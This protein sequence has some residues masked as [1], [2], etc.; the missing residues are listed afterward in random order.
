MAVRAGSPT[1]GAQCNKGSVSLDT[2]I[3]HVECVESGSG[4]NKHAVVTLV[5][6]DDTKNPALKG[7]RLELDQHDGFWDFIGL[8]IGI[9]TSSVEV[10]IDYGVLE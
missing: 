1:M 4:E 10:T 3:V 7:K 6:D 2:M 8:W 5:V 9:R